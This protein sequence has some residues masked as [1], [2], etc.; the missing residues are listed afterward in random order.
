LEVKKF[1]IALK[2][3]ERDK[4]KELGVV[5]P[6]E[7]PS[8]YNHPSKELL[9]RASFVRQIR[10]GILKISQLPNQIPKSKIY[11]PLSW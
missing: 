7:Y 11:K 10:K 2:P 6:F 3:K 9:K 4:S 8:R 1:I 5:F